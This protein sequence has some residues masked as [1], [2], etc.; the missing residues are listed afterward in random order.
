MI[1]AAPIALAVFAI[2]GLAG[3]WQGL[4]PPILLAG[5]LWLPGHV[6]SGLASTDRSGLPLRGPGR[7]AVDAL[8][9]LA[10]VIMAI[11]PLVVSS[12]GLDS[13]PI[14]LGSIYAVVALWALTHLGARDRVGP[15]LTPE[16][17]LEW[18]AAALC[19]VVLLPPVLS[20]A[21]G[22]VDD[23][24]DLAFVRA[25][26]QRPLLS[27]HE[28]ILGSHLVHPRFAWN[29]WLLLQALVCKLSGA[30]A[31]LFQQT[32]MPALVCLLSVAATAALAQS[33][34]SPRQAWAR[35]GALVFMPLWLYG[36]EAVP[37][38]SRLHQ[39]KFVAALVAA[40]T[41]LALLARFLGRPSA[42]AWLLVG[43]AA[44]VTCSIHS[45]VFGFALLIGGLTAVSW[46]AGRIETDRSVAR[47]RAF[48]LVALLLPIAYPLWQWL[49]LSGLFAAQGISLGAPG[50]PVVRA[51]LWLDRLWWPNSP[52]YIVKP[53]A[54]F[55]P[56]AVLALPGLLQAWRQRREG[57]ARL[58]LI[59]S[60]LPC[61]AAFIPGIAALAGRA[62]VPWML[63]R[64]VWLVPVALLGGSTLAWA[65]ADQSRRR[66]A[67]RAIVVASALLL[68]LPIAG[69]RYRRGM[70]QRPYARP[71]YPLA[72]TLHA[73][74][75]LS[76][77]PLPGTVLAPMGFSELVPAM[78]GRPAVAISERGTVVFSSTETQAYTRL[79]DRA[80]FFSF[81]TE[82]QRRRQLAAKYGAAYAVFR[83]HYI[84][85]GAE[86]RLL[87]RFSAEGF[88]VRRGAGDV[89]LWSALRSSLQDRLP[90]EWPIVYSNHDFWIVACGDAVVSGRG[91]PKPLTSAAGDD[92]TW[93]RVFAPDRPAR[94]QA[95]G[96]SQV[97]AGIV[98]YPSGEVTAR[99][100]PLAAGSADEPIWASG[101]APWDDGPSSA[102]LTIGLGR[103]CTVDAVEVVPFLR[104]HRR[105]V[106]EV[107]VGSAMRRER[108]F[109][110]KAITLRLDAR[111]RS[112]V[113]VEVR[114][115]L[116]RPFGLSDVRVIG[117][118]KSCDRPPSLTGPR[119]GLRSQVNDAIGMQDL[120][121]L[122]A[123]Y[124]RDARPAIAL[125]HKLSVRDAD[126]DAEA[127]L[128]LA[129]RRDPGL[130]PASV[131]LG[132]L[133]D[134]LGD[135]TSALALYRQAVRAD[136]HDAWAR[137]CLAWAD[138]RRGRPLQAIYQA[139]R[140]AGFDERYADAYT[141][142]GMAARSIGLGRWATESFRKAMRLDPQRDWPYLELASSLLAERNPAQAK[143]VLSRYLKLNPSSVSV[144]ARMLA[145]GGRADAGPPDRSP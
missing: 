83:R 91:F 90:P 67:K 8:L 119:P 36:T 133:R 106:F 88:L 82:P 56:V 54:V 17:R 98:G 23:W 145:L 49:T 60:L 125:A 115:L 135:E 3:F 97:L 73:Y 65:A 32:Y 35:I 48:A 34:F 77:A 95:K 55:G 81:D 31:V 53:S 15:R 102:Q 7:L 40:P 114:S 71:S 103:R 139:Q 123:R 19:F 116:G 5:I 126:A 86:I 69:D 9:G 24:W 122:A 112:L 70:A 96:D 41:L 141:L 18:A 51:H 43:A 61:M 84:T 16:L 100:L 4:S 78:T 13:A 52:F 101:G 131:E 66:W 50:N 104:K 28:P 76:S 47:V 113:R 39:D 26:V 63:Y 33:V 134:R 6:A 110:G 120:L 45:I 58:L 42:S 144:R 130:A 138:Y 108:A 79:R 132:L 94:V 72:T 25:F 74:R 46:P 85:R 128:A 127:V 22:K 38:F 2:A 21:G 121:G 93:L 87:R 118:E 59:A 44:S 89:A 57:G 27:L 80:E 30:D 136:S 140:A 37:F 105:E 68:V 117:S 99:P 14:V 11:A 129:V 12:A 124:P 111:P 1:V 64:F 142:R 10:F 29:I 20:Y 143:A 92:A 107:R 109:D 75:F 137:G 62:F